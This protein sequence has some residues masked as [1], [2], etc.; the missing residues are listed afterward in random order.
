MGKRMGER[1]ALLTVEFPPRD[2]EMTAVERPRLAGALVTILCHTRVIPDAEMRGQKSDEKW[3]I[4]LVL[5]DLR[6]R[7]V[8]ITEGKTVTLQWRSLAAATLPT[9]RRCPEDTA[10]LLW[11][12]CPKCVTRF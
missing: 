5:K 12:S 9:S 1:Q 8:L 7:Y 2:A 6:T 11:F 10:P 3:D 4:Y